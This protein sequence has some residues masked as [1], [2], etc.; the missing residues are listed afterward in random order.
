NL[1]LTIKGNE[2]C[3]EDIS[4]LLGQHLAELET[5]GESPEIN[6]LRDHVQQT[7]KNIFEEPLLNSRQN[8]TNQQDDNQGDSLEKLLVS[9]F[10]NLRG[11][12]ADFNYKLN[13]VAAQA[14]ELAEMY[15]NKKEK[16]F[17]SEE[18]II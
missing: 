11:V 4:L 2:A 9:E 3:A 5:T 17:G 18:G 6:T 15:K 16:I 10:K 1:N 14:K 13:S 12:I 7:K 8:L